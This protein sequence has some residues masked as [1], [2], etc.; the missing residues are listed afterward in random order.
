MEGFSLLVEVVVGL[1]ADWLWLRGGHQPGGR[2]QVGR[3]KD[4]LTVGCNE[5][6][7]EL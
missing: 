7:E 3:S 2:G 4:V 1:S 6:A 5:R